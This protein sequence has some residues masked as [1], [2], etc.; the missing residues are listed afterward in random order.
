M[1]GVVFRIT[2][3]VQVAIVLVACGDDVKPQDGIRGRWVLKSRTL[4]GGQKINPP[5]VYGIREW[6]PLDKE[7]AHVTMAFSMG[8]EDL[9]LSGSIITLD[10]VGPDAKSFTEEHYFRIGDRPGIETTRTTSDGRVS[11]VDSARKLTF[12][13]GSVQMYGTDKEGN[14]PLLTITHKN[15]TVDL[16][17]RQKDLSGLLP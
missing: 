9:K 4:P 3:F 11:F 2:L 8:K 10:G 14:D 7:R 13:D 12:S 17:K 5:Q 1:L 16:W 6:Y 15:G